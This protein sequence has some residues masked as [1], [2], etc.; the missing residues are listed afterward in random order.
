MM[1]FILAIGRSLAGLS[2]EG[3]I[4]AQKEI[5]TRLREG[6]YVPATGFHAS[7]TTTW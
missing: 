2:V 7:H 5:Q 3:T 1:A 4:R 6:P